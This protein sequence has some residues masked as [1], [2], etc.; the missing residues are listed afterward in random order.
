MIENYGLDER[1]FLVLDVDD[2]KQRDQEYFKALSDELANGGTEAMLHELLQRDISSFNIRQAS[3]T[4]ALIDQK[5]LSMDPADRWW[6][7]ILIKGILPVQNP[8]LDPGRTQ[9]EEWD[10]I[11]IDHLHSDYVANL[12]Q[13]N[14]SCRSS[15]TE[16]GMRLKRLLPAGFPKR[17]AVTD[18]DYGGRTRR[19]TIYHF[20]P[21]ETC[22][23]QFERLA[24]L[25]GFDWQGENPGEEQP[26]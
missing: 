2:S 23:S 5:L 17:G 16:L 22:R 10:K 11:P 24:G 3:Q 7:A 1:R 12:R 19:V 4:T 6:F 20:P 9:F 25:E 21:L 14:T 8:R 15:Q 26:N 18:R 13:T